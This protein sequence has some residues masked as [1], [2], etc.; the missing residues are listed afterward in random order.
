MK[1]FKIASI[2]LITLLTGASLALAQGQQQQMPDVPTSDDVSE[3]ELNQVIDTIGD[4]EPIQVE[5]QEKMQELVEAEDM[6]FD[7]FQQVIMAMQNPQMADEVD[8]TE[9]EQSTIQTIQ[10]DLMEIQGAAQEKM[11]AAI[12]DNGLTAQRYQQIM[13][14]VQQD[15]ELRSRIEERLEN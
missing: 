2:T 14:G 13:M 9:E 1:L 10:P 15:T 7:R 3:E 4:L 8:I 5:T 12:E 11:I 6:S